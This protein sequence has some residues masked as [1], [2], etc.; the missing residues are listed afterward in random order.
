LL[1]SFDST[2]PGQAFLPVG[3]QAA[4]FEQAAHELRYRPG[5]EG[6]AGGQILD[7]AGGGIDPDLITLVDRCS[8]LGRLDDKESGV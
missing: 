7:P 3:H 1:L 6:L 4:G 5:R 2:L 8:G